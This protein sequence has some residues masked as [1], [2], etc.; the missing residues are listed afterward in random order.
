MNTNYLPLAQVGFVIL[1]IVYFAL[2][3]F[4]FRKATALSS[5]SDSKKKS[6][7]R[8]ILF[9]LIG[10]TVFLSIFTYTGIMSDFSRFPFNV[11]PVMAI[12]LITMIIVIFFSKTTSELLDHI[13]QERLIRLQ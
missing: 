6:V 9:C 4:E 7:D 13:P 5:F 10:W 1:S 2:L 12:P 3:I 8:T 11:L